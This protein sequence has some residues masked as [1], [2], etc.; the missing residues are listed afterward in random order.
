MPA[1]DRGPP[2]AGG[3]PA[4]DRRCQRPGPPARRTAR[5]QRRPGGRAPPGRRLADRRR[6]RPAR[7][8]RQGAG[9]RSTPCSSTRPAGPR[10]CASGSPGSAPTA[11]SAWSTS[12]STWPARRDRPVPWV[13]LVNVAAEHHIGPGPALGRVGAQLGRARLPRRPHRPERRRRQPDPP[14]RAGRPGV[15]A[16]VDRR[17]ARR[18][19]RARRRRRA[20]WA[21]S[22]SARAPTPRSRSRCGST[23]TRVFAINPRLTL[24]PAAKGTPVYTD[25]RR[26][27]MLPNQ[28]FAGLA[29]RHRILAGGLWR[30]YRQFAVW[31]APLLVLWRVLRR[32]TALEV[33]ACHDDAQHFTEVY[34]LRPLAVA[35]EAQPPVPLLRRRHHRPLAA[36]ATG[37]AG[38]LRARHRVPRPPPDPEA[39]R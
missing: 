30:I 32:G 23:S 31:H 28:P 9:R 37:P 5:A 39:S 21:S 20:R 16:R 35:D 29:L 3:R 18:R 19:H 17:H 26:A 15:R 8:A 6:R 38:R 13:V 10:R 1:R 4:R 34:A 22:G 36:D 33:V 2:R 24:Y 27:A 11:S 12:R 7:G 14:G 25:R